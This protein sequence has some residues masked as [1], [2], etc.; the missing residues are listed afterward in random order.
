M[1]QKSKSKKVWQLKYLLLVPMVLGMLFYTSCELES[2]SEDE[3]LNKSSLKTTTEISYATV[4]EV[5]VFPGCEDVEDKRICFNNMMQQHI[6]KQFSYPKEAQIAGIEGRVNVMFRIN[7]QG[8]V[9]DLKMRGSN[10][11][12]EKE[13][14]R[15]INKLPKMQPAFHNGNVV[16]IPYSIPVVFKLESSDYLSGES[17]ETNLGEDVPFGIVDEV[18]I[19]PGCESAGDKRACFNDKMQLHISKN[20]SYPLEAQKAGI[21]GR[22][23]VMFTISSKGTIENIIMRGPDKLLEDEVERIIKRLPNMTPGKNKGK[24]I[25]V[26]FSIPVNFKLQ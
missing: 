14:E 5:P 12:L 15:I 9:D 19:F 17:K 10:I 8:H 18:P 1:L 23:S 6:S 25:N 2:K 13:V 4:D 16:A 20:F 26:P 21:Q 22:V 11:L 24:A 3:L 7:E